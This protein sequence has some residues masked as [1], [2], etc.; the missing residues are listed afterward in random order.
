MKFLFTK[1]KKVNTKSISFVGREETHIQWWQKHKL[2]TIGHHENKGMQVRKMMGYGRE[3][4]NPL[5]PLFSF[6]NCHYDLWWLQTVGLF[7]VPFIRMY[8]LG[9]FL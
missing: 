2:W 1:K 9:L 3:P 6:D 7:S 4:K 5:V 8:K